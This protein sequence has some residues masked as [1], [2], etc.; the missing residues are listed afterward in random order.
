MGFITEEL[1]RKR[2]EHND[3]N[4]TTLEEISLHQFEIEKLEL[5]DKFCKRLKILQLQN[6][7]VEKI[8]NLEKLKDLEYL[9]LAVNSI[10]VIEGLEGCESLKYD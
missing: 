9:N 10:S 5:L 8:E 4:L 3:G 2:A 6:N 1:L 7:I